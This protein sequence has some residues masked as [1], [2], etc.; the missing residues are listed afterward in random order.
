MRFLIIEFK[1][2]NSHQRPAVGA[3]LYPNLTVKRMLSELVKKELT[4]KFGNGRSTGKII[5]IVYFCHV[6]TI[7]K[8]NGCYNFQR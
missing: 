4:E 8:E 1:R 5:K 6:T 3:T 2:I 7:L